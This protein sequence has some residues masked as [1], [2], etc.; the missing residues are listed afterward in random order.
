MSWTGK[1][2]ERAYPNLMRL[3]S[4]TW[5]DTNDKQVEFQVPHKCCSVQGFLRD[6]AAAFDATEPW[7]PEW[8]DGVESGR[9]WMTWSTTCPDGMKLYVYAD[10]ETPKPVRITDADPYEPQVTKDPELMVAFDEV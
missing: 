9:G 6:L 1:T 3:P 4:A 2:L 8:C 10:R 7:I 5:F